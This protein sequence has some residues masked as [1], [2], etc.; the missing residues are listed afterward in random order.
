MPARTINIDG[1]EFRLRSIWYQLSPTD[2]APQPD[3][4]LASVVGGGTRVGTV[5][6]IITCRRIKSTRYCRYQLGV[7]AAP[8]LQAVATVC[9]DGV[10]VRDIKAHAL[11]WLP[12]HRR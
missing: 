6:H 4:L 5:Y 11:Y 3:E 1:V 2:P 9:P 7:V 12:R 10:Y 8:D